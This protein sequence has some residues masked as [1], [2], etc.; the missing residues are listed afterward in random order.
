MISLFFFVGFLSVSL[1]DFSSFVCLLFVSLTVVK[2]K[3][4]RAASRVSGCFVDLGSSPR[5]GQDNL[6]F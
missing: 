6:L 3:A 5:H 2:G 1:S 4:K